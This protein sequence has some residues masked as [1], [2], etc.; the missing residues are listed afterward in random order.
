MLRDLGPASSD[1]VTKRRVVLLGEQLVHEQL[2]ECF[3]LRDA[4]AGDLLVE[5]PVDERLKR[6]TTA[7]LRPTFRVPALAFL[8]RRSEIAVASLIGQTRFPVICSVS[9]SLKH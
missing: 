7:T 4:V 8:P 6:Q 3:A 2:G 9:L 5:R 1:V